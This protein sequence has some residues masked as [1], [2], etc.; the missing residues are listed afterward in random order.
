MAFVGP[1]A[2]AQA[3]GLQPFMDFKLTVKYGG[4]ANPPVKAA[5]REAGWRVT[6]GKRWVVCWG[7]IFTAA[8]FAG[9]HEFQRVNHFPG[10]WELGRKDNLYRNVAALKRTKGGGD[11]L[12]IVPRFFI[13]PRDF[14]EFKADLD[15]HPG[16]LYI[17]KPVNS[18]RGRGVRVVVNPHEVP[19]DAK[20]ILLQHYIDDPYTIN[21]YKF[22]MRVYVAATCMDPLRV[23]IYCD[24]LARFAT[25][26]Y[27]GEKADL[28]KRC[29]HLTNYTVNKKSTKLA[30][31]QAAYGVATAAAEDAA[32]KDHAGGQAP[33]PPK[34]TKP[35]SHLPYP[36]SPP[37]PFTSKWSLKELQ[38]HIEAERGGPAWQSVWSQVH[39]IVVGAML[40]AEP[41]L[42]TE[43][44]MKVPHR[45]ICFEVWGFDIMLD[46]SL[47]AWLIEVNT[48]PALN[49]DSPLDKHLK[50][51][52]VADLMNL[53]GPV[54]YDYDAYE[55]EGIARRQ[56]RLTGLAQQ[57]PEGGASSARAKNQTAGGNAADTAP[58]P[59]P[60]KDGRVA[61]AGAGAVGK[62][63]ASSGG[64]GVGLCGPAQIPKTLQEAQEVV[65]HG[66]GP[67]QLPDII[68]E[69]EAELARCRGWERAFPCLSAPTKYLDLFHTPRASNIMLCNYYAQKGASAAERSRMLRAPSARGRPCQG[70]WR[71]GGS[72]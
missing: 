29:M 61:G 45:N 36:P 28:K 3:S 4:I 31:N 5:F 26:A 51:S 47:R 40:A 20:D 33:T 25:E 30:Q 46:S 21:G 63:G 1:A 8:E 2:V 54:P 62:G 11:V 16:R 24:G 23:Y 65:F 42:N 15:R 48:C 32:G 34:G 71:P 39:D 27:S 49:S 56:A 50:T 69:A 37:P 18:S 7:S 17:Q 52:M 67:E 19:R 9:L 14:D 55:M 58:A 44:K 6:K 59:L 64:Q 12:S 13:L 60:Q 57:Q 22:D 41:R 68:V 66:L 10:T 72:G 43:V 35:A 53:V 70:N 38:A